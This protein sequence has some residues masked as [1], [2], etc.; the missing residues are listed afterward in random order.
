MSDA[1]EPASLEE[2]LGP[3]G[4]VA[5]ALAARGGYEVR[6]QQMAMARLVDEGLSSRRHVL[7]EAGTGV[8]KSFAYLVPVLRWAAATGRKAAIATSTIA[9]QEQLV[10]KDQIGRAHV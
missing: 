9:L 6:P 4:A 5:G 8:G 7:I 2:L 10:R 1:P 3:E